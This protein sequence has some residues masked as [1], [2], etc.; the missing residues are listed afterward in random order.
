MPDQKSR[1]DKFIESLGEDVDSAFKKLAHQILKEGAISA[2]DK[3]LIALACAVAVK[4]ELLGSSDI[5]R[6]LFPW[7]PAKRR[8]WRRLQ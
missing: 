3:A 5:N 6:S 7:V 8:C 2:K 4:C 1:A